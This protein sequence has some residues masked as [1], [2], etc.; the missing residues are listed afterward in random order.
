M[1]KTKRHVLS[2]SGIFL[3]LLLATASQVNKIH[4][5][6][7]NTNVQVEERADEGTYL[8]KNDGTRINGDKIMWQ[9]G[10]LLKK[11][12]SIDGKEFKSSEIRGYM[13]NKVYYGRLGSEFIPRVVHGKLNV[14]IQQ[15]QDMQTSSAT[16]HTRMV[17]RSFHYVQRGENGPLIAMGSQKDMKNAVAGCPLAEAL[18]DKS[19]SQIRK[20]IKANP[21]YLNEIFETYNNDCKALR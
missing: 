15:S 21:S 20:A 1:T 12:I 3:F 5:G 4:T 2:F 14:Y 16:G 8:V 6:A 9:D 7:F 11:K 13:R 17:T 10:L 18:A 19:N